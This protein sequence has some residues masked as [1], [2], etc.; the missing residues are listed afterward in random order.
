MVPLAQRH[1]TVLRLDT[2]AADHGSLHCNG[3]ALRQALINLVM[4]AIQ[5][6]HKAEQGEV[7]IST[8][9]LGAELAIR[10]RDNGPGIPEPLRERIFEPFFTT[11]AQE[12]GTGLGLS[13]TR[14]IVVAHGG[15]LTL[16]RAAGAGTVFEMV[17][18]RHPQSTASGGGTTREAL[19]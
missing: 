6:V 19:A 7:V 3:H 14:R 4:N 13:T 8:C 12:G 11:K 2:A 18:P 9:D 5:A 1:H 15:R 17:L 10:V 16:A